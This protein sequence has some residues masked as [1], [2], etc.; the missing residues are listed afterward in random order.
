MALIVQKYGGTSVGS[1]DR[2]RSVA[3]RIARRI[4]AGDRLVVVVSAMGDTTDELLALASEM[5]DAPEERE[6]DLLLS[7]G[8]I[9]SSTLLAMALKHAGHPAVALSGAQ[10]GIGTDRRYGRARILKVDPHRIEAALAAGNVVIVAGFQGT[11]EELDV[12]TLGRGGSDTTAVAL[13]AALK[14][15]RCEI[16]T[17]V[18]GIY[19]ADPRI[20]PKASKLAAVSYE[21]MLELASYGAK[22]MQPRSVELG[23]V[24]NVPIL[25]ASSFS[26]A[27]GTLIG[28]A[29]MMEQRNKVTGIAADTDVARITLRGVPDQPGIAARLFEPLAEAGISVDTIVQNASVERL[30]DL[31]FTVARA[32]VERAM[33]IVRPV[34]AAIGAPEALAD[35]H[36]AKVSVVGA[37]M[38]SG[39]G[40]ASRMFRTL[41]EAGINIEL[42][43]T[44]EIRITCLID[45]EK[46]PL[47]VRA[48]HK[49]FE[50][51]G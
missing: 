18:D 42:I 4:E 9:V 8:E 19:T 16:Y 23:A 44:S 13:A 14:A 46:V 20:E 2:I 50:L 39:P 51:E 45:A 10:A 29:S 30:T 17:D 40:Y 49:A 25:V 5:T 48:L 33:A 37:G 3:T 7:T 31:T 26:E 43:T 35:T 32:E 36:L 15:E 11:T 27:P 21:E 24:F 34:A 38:Q 47:A 6:L 41:F 22:V 1:A 28:G 12:T